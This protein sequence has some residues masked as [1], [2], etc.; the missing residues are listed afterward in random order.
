VDAI[1]ITPG[2]EIAVTE[3]GELFKKLSGQGQ[4]CLILGL[5]ALNGMSQG[6]LRAILAHE[7]GH[8]SNQDT[9]GGNFARQVLISV[10]NMGIRLAL[11]GLAAWYNPA[12]W[13]V[14]GTIA[15]LRRVT[16]CPALRDPG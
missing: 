7:Y 15:A 3:R 5:G 1:Y 9:A 2:P 11:N 4:R 10:R 14:N 8:F 16:W 12:W 6:Q 13:F